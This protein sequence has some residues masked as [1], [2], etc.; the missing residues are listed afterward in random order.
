MRQITGKHALSEALHQGSLDQIILPR[1]M[2]KRYKSLIDDAKKQHIST[3]IL[4]DKDFYKQYGDSKT[5]IGLCKS[6]KQTQILST[7]ALNP[8]THPLIVILDHIQ[9]PHNMGAIIRTAA[10]LGINALIFPKDRSCQLTDTVTKVSSGG[11]ECLPLLKVTNLAREIDRLKEKGYWIY[12]ADS[13][14]GM[15]LSQVRFHHPSVLVVGN[16]GKGLSSLLIKKLDQAV[17]IPMSGPISSLNVSVATGII[18]H[19]MIEA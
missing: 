12:G 3:Q 10:G 16:E 1:K 6:K 2:N 17:Y 7:E 4:E 8:E 18:L 15:S 19:K 11:T 5:I 14:Q 9:D 13:T